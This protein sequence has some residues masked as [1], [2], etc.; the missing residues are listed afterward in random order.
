MARKVTQEDILKMNTLYIQPETH[1]YAAVARITGFSPSTVK[2]YIIDNFSISTERK[3]WSG[4]LPQPGSFLI[5]T[6]DLSDDE[7]AEIEELR[8]EITI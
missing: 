3:I 8:K 2:K 4:E 6:D 7:R 1:S 5:T